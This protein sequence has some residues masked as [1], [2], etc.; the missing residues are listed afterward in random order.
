MEF[1]SKLKA[2]IVVMGGGNAGLVAAIEARNQGA[3]V[4]L[5]E[6]GP[7]HKRGGNN[8]ASGGHFRVAWEKGTEDLQ[9]VLQGA[10][11]PTE[12]IVI[13]PYTRGNIL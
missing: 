1:K 3:T 11:L 4:L 5:L 2:D 6:K 12:E 7:K 9:S 8:R 10:T 13:E